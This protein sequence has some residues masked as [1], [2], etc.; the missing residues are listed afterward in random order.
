MR[1]PPARFG[2]VYPEVASRQHVLSIVPV[3]EQALAQAHLTLADVNAIAVTRGPGLAGSLVVGLNA[4][5]GLA[6]GA[7]K[8]LVGVNHLEGHIY[9][10][11]GGMGKTSLAV[12]A[13]E[14]A[15]A[16]FDRVLFVST[17]NQKLTPEGAVALSNSI[18]PEY[19]ELLSQTARL[20]GLPYPGGPSVQKAAEGGNPKAFHFPRARTDGAW[21]FSFSGIKTAVLREVRRMQAE[22][23]PIPVADMAASFQAAVVD[24]LLTKTLAAAREFGA[25]EILVA[26]GVSANTALREAFLAQTEFKVNIPRFAYCTDNAAMIASAGYFRYALGHRSTFDIDVMPTWPLS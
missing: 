26:G 14:L 23:Q 18:V 19:P 7:D 15:R 17:K 2:G 16:Q 13:A 21:D 11:P 12:R 6:L 4:A 22:G 20:L 5:K 3:V 24:I 10:G 1:Q 8:P 25:Q 9:Y